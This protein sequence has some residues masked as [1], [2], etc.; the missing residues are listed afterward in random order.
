MTAINFTCTQSQAD[1]HQLDC[2]YPAFVGG[3]GSGKTE[4]MVQAAIMD[5]IMC[6]D[7]AVALYE[8]TYDLVRLI[9]APRM[10]ERLTEAGIEYTYNKSENIIHTNGYG[11][12]I[13][14]TLDNP[15]RIVGYEAFRSHVDEIDT[16]RKVHAEE[17]W[18]KI[19]ARN[20]YS[21][22][23]VQNRVAAYTTPEGFQFVYE[24]W[25][26]SP[27]DGYEY[28]SAPTYANP[29]LPGDY[30]E[31]LR[32]SYP[33]QLVEA[34][35]EGRFVNLT[36]GSVYSS[37]DRERNS[38]DVTYRSREPLHIGMDFNVNH[39]AAVVNVVRGDSA[40]AVEELTEIRD[41]PA[42]IKIIQEKYPSHSVVVY[43]DASGY[44][45]KSVDAS[46][47]DINELKQAGFLINAPRRNGRVKDRVASFNRA[48]LDSQG[49][50]RYWVNVEK[51][52]TLA[53]SLEQQAYDKNGE[54]DK[55]GGL[56][57]ILDAAGYFVV[58]QFP[59]KTKPAT[60][61]PIRWS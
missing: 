6:P 22:T 32:A 11:D 41:T 58:R 38:T 15:S 52:P 39:M 14:R 18:Q 10:E 31:G 23:G 37:F 7:G 55:S 17:V 34:Y 28:V 19:I 48:L 59:I 53:L 35:I 8:P 45:T 61:Q 47:S 1:F 9:L 42:M 21:A 4:A 24:Q 16:L 46:R 60:N 12:F 25:E 13:L 5:K 3:F 43:P 27:A 56:D 2:K 50:I 57:H 51:C 44:S 54:P 40:Y 20:R 36:S 29:F 30:I 33:D 49:S 26:K